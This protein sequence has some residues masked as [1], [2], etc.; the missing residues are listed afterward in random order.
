MKATDTNYTEFLCSLIA[1]YG[2]DQEMILYCI[3]NTDAVVKFADGSLFVISRPDI[4][5][6]FCFDDS[7]DYDGAVKMAQR[8]RTSADYFRAQNLAQIDRQVAAWKKYREAAALRYAPGSDYR[9]PMFIRNWNRDIDD[10]DFR[11]VFATE[12]G[13]WYNF[14][15]SDRLCRW[16]TPDDCDRVLAALEGTRERFAK[17]IETYLKRYGTSKVHSWHYWGMA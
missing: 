3:K 12:N 1:K 16:I 15:A 14:D 17:R 8:A 10:P 11:E 9:R 2:H 7:Y 5:K 13:E 4:E 6:D